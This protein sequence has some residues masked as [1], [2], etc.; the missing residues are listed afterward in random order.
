MRGLTTVMALAM[1]AVAMVGGPA[2]AVAAERTVSA[3]VLAVRLQGPAPPTVLDVRGADEFAEGH[4]PGAVLIPHDQVPARL[5]ELGPPREIVL[6]CRSG[7]R[8]RMAGPA[9]EQ[10]GFEVIYLDGDYPG[11]VAGERP[12]AYGAGGDAAR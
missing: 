6:Y 7:R 5:G 3:E 9:L 2:T 12:V 8:A 10:A 4:L 11:W 1:T